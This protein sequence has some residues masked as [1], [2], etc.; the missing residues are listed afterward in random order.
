MFDMWGGGGEK[1]RDEGRN[2]DIKPRKAALCLG[3]RWQTLSYS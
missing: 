2:D 3:G 1:V